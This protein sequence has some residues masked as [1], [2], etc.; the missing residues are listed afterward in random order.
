MGRE[1]RRQPR[2][3]VSGRVEVFDTMRELAIGHLG[4]VSMG[5][6]L[7]VANRALTED[8]LY[9]LSFELPNTAG[10]RLS[11]EVGAHILWQEQANTPGYFWVGMRF[12]G[13]PPDTVRQLRAWSSMTEG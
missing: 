4:N 13:L 6:M 3:A 2:R 9:Q 1:A 12:L 8:G 10:D 11:V 7:L 5:G